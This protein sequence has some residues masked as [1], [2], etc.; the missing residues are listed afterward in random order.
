MTREDYLTKAAK[1]FN[2]KI[3]ATG[4]VDKIKRYTVSI[5]SPLTGDRKGKVGGVCYYQDDSKPD[6]IYISPRWGQDVDIL[7]V[8]L[9][10]I[11]HVAAPKAGH[12]GLFRKIALAVGL[13]APMKSTPASPKLL[14]ELENLATELGKFPHE[15]L[16]SSEITGD[17]KKK[18]GTRL[19]K[20]SCPKCEYN[21]RMT[22][23]W[24]DEGLPK[25]PIHDET[26]T[27]A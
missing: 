20:V 5:G 27:I 13:E 18:Q 2:D 3:L 23:K 9:H 4:L 25:C 15:A 21:V 22:Q 26:M 19:L 16:G 11:I 10:E 12:R 6:Q 7:R 17:K 14:A 8:L 24:V 1:V